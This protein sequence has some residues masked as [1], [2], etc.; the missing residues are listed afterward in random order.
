MGNGGNADL[1]T[2]YISLYF[3][4]IYNPT[5]IR[6]MPEMFWLEGT[7][8][9]GLLY[10]VPEPGMHFGMFLPRNTLDLITGDIIVLRIPL[11]N[12]SRS[13]SAQTPPRA[14]LPSIQVISRSIPP[15]WGSADLGPHES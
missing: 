1:S 11:N 7:R 10:P 12:T 9:I 3:L 4:Y 8:A 2:F 6:S 5:V 14:N 13:N 15:R